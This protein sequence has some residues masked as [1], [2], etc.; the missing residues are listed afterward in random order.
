V[1]YKNSLTSPYPPKSPHPDDFIAEIY[2]TFKKEL[3]A[4]I[5]KLFHK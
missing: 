5:L 4:T 1:K 2:N 3:I